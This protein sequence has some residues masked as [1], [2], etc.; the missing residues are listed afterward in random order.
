MKIGELSSS[1]G[2][3]VR[4]IRFYEEEG[5]LAAPPRSASGYRD[6]PEGEVGRL[7]WIVAAQRAGLMLAEIRGVLDLRDE[8]Q[9]P[10]EH[11]V[12]LLEAK[13]TD[14]ELRIVEL[15]SFKSEL[16]VLIERASAMDPST[17][18]GTV[19]CQVIP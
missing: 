6:Y 14:I 17:C 18:D 19:I 3:P 16:S 15:R 4:T 13:R 12:K 11:T 9:A 8:G 2:V 1:T 7:E 5:L 10:C